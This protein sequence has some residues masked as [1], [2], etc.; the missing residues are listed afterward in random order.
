MPQPVVVPVVAPGADLHKGSFASTDH[1]VVQHDRVDQ[2]QLPDP[3]QV[4]YK[5]L[6]TGQAGAQGGGER[7]GPIAGGPRRGG[8]HRLGCLGAIAH[9]DQRRSRTQKPS[10][11]GLVRVLL[12]R[13]HMKAGPPHPGRGQT[14]PF[15]RAQPIVDLVEQRGTRDGFDELTRAQGRVQHESRRGLPE[16]AA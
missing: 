12:G 2:L 6:A 1:G 4:P 13:Q 10:S 16:A 5:H 11:D 7:D 14:L 15:G 3:F 8:E 9:E